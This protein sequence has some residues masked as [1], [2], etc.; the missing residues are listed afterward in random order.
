MIV[1]SNASGATPMELFLVISFR[2]GY[3]VGEVCVP[4]IKQFPVTKPSLKICVALQPCG[5]R[6]VAGFI[7]FFVDSALPH[8]WLP[9]QLLFAGCIFL[10]FMKK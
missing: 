7:G 6:L 9:N 5:H 10:L 1:G 8:A 4:G 2:D 3:D